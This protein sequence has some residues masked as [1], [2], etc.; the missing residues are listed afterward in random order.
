[1]PTSPSQ[2]DTPPPAVT[3]CTC[4]YDL[5]G[6]P[7]DAAAK[8]P[9]CGAV[10]ADLMPIKPWLKR[11]LVI[12]MIG[13]SP[14]PVSWFAF[15]VLHIADR[16]SNSASL[17]YD[18]LLVFA[19]VAS[20]FMSVSLITSLVASVFF[21]RYQWRSKTVFARVVLVVPLTVVF[22]IVNYTLFIIGALWY[23]VPRM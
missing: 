2:S 12:A 6:L 10:V 15:L 21:M 3:T 22:W 18:P 23:I 7:E 5:T 20:S 17:Q 8:C 16:L 1:M 9:E 11:W 14:V 19:I 4:G 13:V